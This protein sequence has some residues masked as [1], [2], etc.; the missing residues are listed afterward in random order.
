MP[1][2][3]MPPSSLP[4]SSLV[5]PGALVA[6]K[7]RVESVLAV[8]GMGVVAAARNEALDQPV[9][10]KLLRQDIAASAEATAR[11]LQEARLSAKLQG[12]HIV[13]VFDVGT[14]EAGIP[15]MVMERL[16]G[17]DLQYLLDAAGP[18]PIRDAVDHVL[19]AL[20]AIAEAHAAGVV[21]RDLKPANLFLAD[22]PDGSRRIKVLDFGIS[23]PHGV[24]A[25]SEGPPLTAVEQVVGSPGFMS[26][27]QMMRPRDVD[28]R[29]DVWSIGVVLHTLVT[30]EPPFRGE[31]VAG[32]MASILYGTPP[33]L[34]EKRPDAPAALQRVV[35]G[36][37]ERDQAARIGDVAQLAK[38][39]APLGSSWA[40]LSVERIEKA[41]G[42]ASPAGRTLLR[43]VVPSG[44]D[45]VAEIAR[46]A[47]AM[48]YRNKRILLVAVAVIVACVGAALGILLV[49]GGDEGAPGAAA[50]SVS[51]AAAPA[52]TAAA[53]PPSASPSTT[54]GAAASPS[55][56][57]TVPVATAPVAPAGT[58]AAGPRP[59]KS[60]SSSPPASAGAKAPL[61]KDDEAKLLGDR[62]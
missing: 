7:Y 52:A 6:G 27:E 30:G 61:T 33:R 15:Y 54:Q 47:S 3:S 10:L 58:G 11:F 17:N 62:K 19:Q 4:P 13:R 44:A 16:H 28:A 46:A 40:K 14:T 37:L 34:R 21:H 26:P 8:G 60:S 55:G 23:K 32:V 48:R 20:E 2:A 38:L 56:A 39:L 57:S 18:L 5:Q 42:A 22:R 9:V 43:N 45:P 35:D 50:P 59:V 31:T 53:A 29:T 25:R 49:T 12:E 1:P 51:A 41:L 24:D 36:C